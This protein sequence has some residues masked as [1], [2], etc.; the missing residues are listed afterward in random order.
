MICD[1]E[2]HRP[3]ASDETDVLEG[4]KKEQCFAS[5][6]NLSTRLHKIKPKP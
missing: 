2:S 3:E 4:M 1:S 6:A 5:V